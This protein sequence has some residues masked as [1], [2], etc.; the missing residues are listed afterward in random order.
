MTLSIKQR[1]TLIAVLLSGCILAPVAITLDLSIQHEIEARGIEQAG[2]NALQVNYSI[3]NQ[4]D[5]DIL[6]DFAG[7]RIQFDKLNIPFSDW[8]V[9]RQN[10]TVE[11]AQGLFQRISGLRVGRPTRLLRL[12]P[13]Q[14]YS[15][16]SIPMN[17]EKPLV[18]AR[19]P[20]KAR[21]AI[22]Q[23]VPDA[24]FLWAKSDVEDRH[25]VYAVQ[26]LCG[27]HIADISVT[28]AGDV[29]QIQEDDL[30]K[31]LP[32]GLEITLADGH[33]LQTPRIVGWQACDSELIAIMQGHDPKGEP[34]RTGVNR[35]GEQYG[36][37][38][39]GRV[40]RKLDESRLWIMLAGDISE[41]VMRSRLA[42]RAI[43]ASAFMVWVFIGIITWQITKHAV[44]PVQ[45][46]I[47]QAERIDLPRLHERLPVRGGD[48]ELSHIARTVNKMLDR[49]QNAYR[50]EQQFTGDASHEMRNPLAKMIAEI[51]LAQSR[52]RDPREYQAIL[53]RLKKYAEGMQQL[54]ESLLML[55]RLDGRLQNLEIQPFDVADLAMEILRAL[56]RESAQRIQLELG[57]SDAPMQAVGH[58]HLIK[59]L[60]N[61]LIDNALR[62]S[63]P[64]SRVTLKITKHAGRVGLAVEDAGPGI[65]EDHVTSA[66]NRFHRLE[67]SRS[68]QTGGAG[69]GLSIVKAIADVHHTTVTLTPG[70]QGCGTRAWFELPAFEGDT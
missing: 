23:R 43:L 49:I 45:A 54:I 44:K 61:N 66:F 6:V 2:S 12:G 30:A 5:E 11:I 33:I 55:A 34:V 18:W 24:E 32:A 46:M 52:P 47:R 59:V 69:L 60:L 26:M 14:V 16:A 50:R 25:N 19:I 48:D 63:P 7:E 42:G 28:Q 68:K 65:P 58:R 57:G 9:M 41:E 38:P 20:E 13:D 35:F 70:A 4:L 21:D 8:A 40:T 3:W 17:R 1:L 56:P 53:G 67:K 31:T 51:D 10:G 27:D 15:V 29:I 39:D 36:L 22:L 37:T 64:Q 62:Y